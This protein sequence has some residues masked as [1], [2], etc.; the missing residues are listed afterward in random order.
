MRQHDC[1]VC[2]RTWETPCI[3]GFGRA[4]HWA[5]W[6]LCSA[7]PRSTGHNEACTPEDRKN[8]ASIRGEIEKL[9]RELAM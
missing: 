3:D 1:R 4:C 7:N 6:D 2:G 9:N 5:A 8:L